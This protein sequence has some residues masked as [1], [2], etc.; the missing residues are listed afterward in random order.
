MGA[1]VGSSLGASVGASVGA[2]VGG[3]DG[4]GTGAVSYTHLR[5]VSSV[6]ASVARVANMAAPLA[7][8]KR[9]V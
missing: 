6:K 1:S 3:T 7:T 2:L 5:S 4:E 9:C 8:A